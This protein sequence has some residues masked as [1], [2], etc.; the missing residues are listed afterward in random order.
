M[1]TFFRHVFLLLFFGCVSYITN[2][3]LYSSFTVFVKI[4]FW[5]LRK[6]DTIFFSDALRIENR[7]IEQ[8]IR[9]IFFLDNFPDTE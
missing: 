7:M 8:T 9:S 5:L 6:G 4:T 3:D 1:K 2:A